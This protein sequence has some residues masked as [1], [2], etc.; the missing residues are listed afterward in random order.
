LNTA[1]GT[2]FTHYRGLFKDLYYC[3]SP[4]A[5]TPGTEIDFVFS[6][7]TYTAVKM[8]NNNNVGANIYM[9]KV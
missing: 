3:A 7:T 6:G 4:S 5:S 2:T 8:R 9:A 1:V